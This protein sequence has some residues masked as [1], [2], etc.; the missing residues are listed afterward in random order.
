MA[1]QQVAA[2]HDGA[3]HACAKRQHD[4][5]LQA[6]R[7]APD[8]LRRERDARRVIGEHGH[9]ERQANEIGEAQPF[10]KMQ[11]SGERFDLRAVR[12][13]NALAANPDSGRH[14]S[15]F[16]QPANGVVQ[17]GQKCV[18]IRRSLNRARRQNRAT[19]IHHA[20]ANL[21]SSDIDS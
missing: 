13:D 14:G 10:E 6:M 1:A 7:G 9:V 17:G 12:V 20:S 21:R 2:R 18:E 11:C 5:V 15:R 4:H 8:H 16:E 19:L 3:A